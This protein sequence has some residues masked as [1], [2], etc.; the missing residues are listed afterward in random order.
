MHRFLQNFWTKTNWLHQ[1]VHN[2]LEKFMFLPRYDHF[3]F[4]TFI[5]VTRLVFALWLLLSLVKTEAKHLF[6]LGTLLKPF[7]S[8]PS[9]YTGLVF[10]H[11]HTKKILNGKKFLTVIAS[12]IHFDILTVLFYSY[13][14]FSMNLHPHFPVLSYSIILN[15]KGAYSLR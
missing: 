13:T 10:W 9:L 5:S 15:C 4:C 11:T 14:A 8:T 6:S 1:H 2:N 7:L 3:C 12:L